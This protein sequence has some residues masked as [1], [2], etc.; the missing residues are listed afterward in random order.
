MYTIK[1]FSEKTGLPATTIRYYD[2][3]GLFPGLARKESGYRLFSESD[4]EFVR[5]VECLKGTGMSIKDIRRFVAWVQQGDASLSERHEMFQERKRAVQAQMEQL[6]RMLDL[7]ERKCRY[8]EVALA[9]GT[10]AVHRAKGQVAFA[11]DSSSLLQIE[12]S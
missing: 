11:V 8:Y 10:E 6:Q 5:I 9:A 4:V 7:I 3:E 12:S 2:K 1:E